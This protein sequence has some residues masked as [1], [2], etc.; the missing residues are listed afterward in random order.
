MRYMNLTGLNIKSMVNCI[1]R[2]DYPAL[3]ELMEKI[4]SM[5]KETRQVRMTA[6]NGHDISFDNV[7][8]RPV[9]REDGYART[10]GMHMIAGRFPGIGA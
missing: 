4:Q 7:P 3:G 6:L 9:L 1:G 8:G 2:V 10:G 5:L